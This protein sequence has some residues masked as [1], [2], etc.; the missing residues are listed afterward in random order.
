MT[1][2][3]ATFSVLKDHVK[4][5]VSQDSVAIDNLGNKNDDTWTV[6]FFFYFILL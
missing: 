4:W 6:F 3:L 5:K 2:V 1:T